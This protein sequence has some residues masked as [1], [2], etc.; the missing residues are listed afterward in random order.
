MLSEQEIIEGCINCDRAAQKALF[1]LCHQ[2]LNNVCL[3]YSNSAHDAQDLMQ[4]TFIKV[5]Q[6]IGSFKG[7]SSLTSWIC[8]IA[9]NTAMSNFRKLKKFRLVDLDSVQLEQ[10]EDEEYGDLP[11]P[12][13][14]KAI[15][16]LRKLPEG[17]RMVLNL[18]AVEKYS[19]QQIADELG[20]SVGTSKSQ[21]ARARK[22][23]REMVNYK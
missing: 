8:S 20:I 16:A 21:L 9:V 4:D 11:E 19:H 17:Y 6:K 23:I 3:R 13:V 18:Y 12:N 2:K 10:I 22:K 7:K 5:Y 15:E 1:D 14:D